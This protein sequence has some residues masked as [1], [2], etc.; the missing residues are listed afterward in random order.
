M[1]K[2]DYTLQTPEE[3]KVL[4]E[5]IIQERGDELSS[6]YLEILADYIIL[7]MEKQEKKEKKILTDNRMSTV[8]KREKSFEGLAAALESGEDGLYNMINQEEDKQV[9]FQPKVSITKK[10]IEEI[11]FLRQLREAIEEWEPRKFTATGH[12]AY[13]IRKALIEMRKDQYLIKNAYRCPTGIIPTPGLKGYIKLEDKTCKFDEDGY[14]I[15]EGFTFLNP[16]VCG[17]ILCN[18]SMLKQNSYSQY[19][20]DLWYIMEDFDNLCAAA[21]KDYPVYEKI[22]ELK[23]DGLS[24]ILIQQAILD[25]FNVLYTI[26]HISTL[27]RQKI[28]KII[29]DCAEDLFLDHYYLEVEK[30][31]YKKCTRCGEIKLAH[32]K[33]F[34]K[35]KSNK[36]GFYSICKACRN[37][38][39]KI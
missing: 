14:P 9:I 22:V 18:Y 7:C 35:N 20:A 29:A 3:R 38:K 23:I 19:E 13:I 34:S 21:L 2:L 16:K 1:I 15:P 37:K 39:E 24:N 31:K 10:D 12:D 33:Y 36:D 26:E 17:A 28:P 11:P 30:G 25:E 4:V 27:W 6:R 32:N 5:K 8:K